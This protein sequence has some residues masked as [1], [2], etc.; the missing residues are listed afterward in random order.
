MRKKR[1]F[2]GG[3][4]F[5]GANSADGF[6]SFFDDMLHDVDRVYIMKGGPGTGKSSF[7]RQAAEYAHRCG[8]SVEYYACSSDPDSL[9]GIVVDGSIAIVDGTAPHVCEPKLVGARD[10]I[11]D[12]GRFWDSGL[13]SSHREEIESLVEKK[14]TCYKLAYR[15]LD[16][17][18]RVKDINL[19]LILPYV[20]TEKAEHA[21]SRLFSDIKTGGGGERIVGMID[22][23]GIKGK[24][25]LDTYEFYADKTYAIEDLYG[26]GTLFLRLMINSALKTDTPIVVSFDPLDCESPKA[27]FFPNDKRAFIISDKDSSLVADARINMRRFFDTGSASVIKREHRQNEKHFDAFVSSALDCLASAGDAHFELE[28]IYSSCMD[29][30]A[31]EEYCEELLKRI[32]G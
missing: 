8:R 29:F 23:Y 9:D 4:L 26:S 5:C 12:L 17:A 32:F 21:V 1:Q 28:K 16:A 30:D 25:R 18:K 24:V 13:L 31:K 14:S 20:K 11:V 10:E 3:M 15:Y 2:D 27:L 22:S 6:V 19:S 7:L